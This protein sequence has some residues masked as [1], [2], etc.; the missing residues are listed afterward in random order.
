LWDLL[1]PGGSYIFIA[2]KPYYESELVKNIYGHWPMDWMAIAEATFGKPEVYD[3][4]FNEVKGYYKRVYSKK[5]GV[6]LF[7]D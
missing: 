7:D 6:Y 2:A 1:S 4:K 5:E 3:D